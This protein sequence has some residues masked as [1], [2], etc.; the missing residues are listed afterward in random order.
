MTVA[1]VLTVAAV[2]IAVAVLIV[3][4]ARLEAPTAA[5]VAVIVPVDLMYARAAE[6]VPVIALGAVIVQAAPIAVVETKR[7]NPYDQIFR[8]RS[9]IWKSVN[10]FAAT[11]MAR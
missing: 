8:L 6:I 10:G 9:S 7:N 2:L 5:L 11:A 4:V 3:V 1:Q